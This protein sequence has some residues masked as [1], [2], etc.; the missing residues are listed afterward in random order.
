MR[1]KI[2]IGNWKMNGSLASIKLLSKSLHEVV[3]FDKKKLEVV[4]C[5]PSPYLNYCNQNIRGISLGAQNVSQHDKG[6]F[7]GEISLHMLK[8]FNCK[9]VLLGHSERRSLFGEDNIIIS[10]KNKK[11]T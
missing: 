3:H 7:T 4:I 8:D 5:A 1:R 10:K 6:A 9:Y 2:I 11:N